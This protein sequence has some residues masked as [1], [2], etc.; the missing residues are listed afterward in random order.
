MKALMISSKPANNL[1]Y[2]VHLRILN[3]P[4][5]PSRKSLVCS[6]WPIRCAESQSSQKFSQMHN[7]SVPWGEV[8]CAS[9]QT[10]KGEKSFPHSWVSHTWSF[11]AFPFSVALLP[12]TISSQHGVS[13]FYSQL[14]GSICLL[15][16]CTLTGIHIHFASTGSRKT[17]TRNEHNPL[18]TGHTFLP[19]FWLGNTHYEHFPKRSRQQSLFAGLQAPCKCVVS[20]GGGN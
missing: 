18:N 15:V 16:W 12:S 9:M 3:W 6:K 13:K 2:I 19:D 17:C 20:P 14:G 1:H 11:Q 4:L 10:Q 8:V 5:P 7:L